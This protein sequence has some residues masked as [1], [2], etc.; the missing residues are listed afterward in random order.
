MPEA[1]DAGETGA[2]MQR[3]CPVVQT[4]HSHPAAAAAADGGDGA[5][6][7]LPVDAVHVQNADAAAACRRIRCR[8]IRHTGA[9]CRTRA[10]CISCSC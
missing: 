7:V 9:C 5:V 3:V 8:N 4:V 10:G 6:L 2:R 1:T